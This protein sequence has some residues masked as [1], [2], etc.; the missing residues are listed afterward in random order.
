MLHGAQNMKKLAKA[1]LF[2]FDCSYFLIS[3]HDSSIILMLR[4]LKYTK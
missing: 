3:D 2:T 4:I 1:S